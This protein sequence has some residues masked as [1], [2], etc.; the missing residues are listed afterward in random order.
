[1][2]VARTDIVGR[3]ARSRRPRAPTSR[4]LMNWRPNRSCSGATRALWRAGI[5][6]SLRSPSRAARRDC[7]GH[8]RQTGC[9]G[10]DLRAPSSRKGERRSRAGPGRSRSGEDGH[11]GWR[12]RAGGA[13]HPPGRR[14]RQ[15][16]H[17]AGRG[18]DPGRRRTAQLAGGL[19]ADE[20]QVMKVGMA[21]EVTCVSKPMTIIP[22]VVTDVQDFIAAGQFR[23]GEQLVD[24]QQVTRPGTILVFLEPLYEGGRWRAA[25]QQLHR[26]RLHQQPR[27]DRLEGHQHDAAHRSPR[28]G[29]RRARACHDPAH[30][31]A[32]ASIQTLVFSGH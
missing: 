19:W 32:G 28:G 3:K 22:M 15:S 25:W 4:P 31:G 10:Q 8:G 9:R 21:A 30:P 11:P 17:A 12:Q 29:C 23:G 1:M 18:P 26:Q 24:P 6:R 2:V 5:S 13:V 16:V 14:H 7:G 20:A 27:C